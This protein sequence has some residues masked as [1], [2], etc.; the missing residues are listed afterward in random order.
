MKALTID[1]DLLRNMVED[2]VQLRKIAEH[3]GCCRSTIDRRMRKLGLNSKRTGPKSGKRHPD[4]KGGVR[5]VKGYR[6]IYAPF[7]PRATKQ[8]YVAEHRLVMECKLERFLHPKEIVH[9]V[10]GNPLNNDESNLVVFRTNGA[11]LKHELSGKVP[12]WTD[13]GKKRLQ[14]AL[15]KALRHR[16]ID[17]QPKFYDQAEPQPKNRRQE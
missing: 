8:N 15:E 16:G 12:K 4:W 11:H 17:T 9:H 10:D 1:D 5:L 3:F 2:D 7:H 6:Y 13:D 14:E